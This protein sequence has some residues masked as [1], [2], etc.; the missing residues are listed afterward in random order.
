MPAGGQSAGI[1]RFG[2]SSTFY[3]VS[4]I[5]KKKDLG[6]VQKEIYQKKIDKGFNVTDI[7]KELC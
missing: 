7:N 3:V 5:M 6:K 1:S 4:F 2:F